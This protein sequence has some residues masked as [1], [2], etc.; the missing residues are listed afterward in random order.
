MDDRYA[1]KMTEICDPNLDQWETSL[2]IELADE[3][4]TRIVIGW[5]GRRYRPVL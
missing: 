2:H 5:K 1:A 3:F 4:V